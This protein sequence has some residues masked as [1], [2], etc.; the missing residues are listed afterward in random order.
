[1]KSKK[2]LKVA[3]SGSGTLFYLHI[4]A[5]KRLLQDYYI[6]QGVATS[7]GSIVLGLLSNGYSIEEVEK[8]AMEIDLQKSVD[9]SW[10]FI[11]RMG[12]IEGTRLKNVFTSLMNK[13][14][15]NAIFPITITTTNLTT[16]KANMFSSLTHSLPI[17][18]VI[19][20]SMSIPLL[21]KHTTINGEIHVDGGVTNNFPIDFF[22]DS[23]VVGIKIEGDWNS[24]AIDPPKGI[25]NVFGHVVNYCLALVMVMMTAIEKKHMEDGQYAKTIVIKA[26]YNGT[27]FDFS[28]KEKR[29]MISMGYNHA[30]DFLKKLKTDSID[31]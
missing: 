16:G 10:N 3:L 17:S 27:R 15:S 8:I 26:P 31:L 2:P 20:A 5:L 1:M 21:F 30:H 12:L 9:F 24:P 18:E 13:P 22:K 29:D 23:N 4:G 28:A 7:G 14:I 6:D 25:F 19:R 11:D